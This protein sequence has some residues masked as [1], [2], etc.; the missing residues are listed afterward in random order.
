MIF[1]SGGVSDSSVL[2]ELS[3]IE[4]GEFEPVDNDGWN[5][6]T[7]Q[8]SNTY[9]AED[10]SKVV[11]NGVLVDQTSLTVTADGTYDTTLNNSI[12]VNTAPS[13]T[14]TITQNGTYNI[15][16]YSSAIVS[17]FDGGARV[18]SAI[19]DTPYIDGMEL[20]GEQL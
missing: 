5:K 11:D 1:N 3:V 12:T 7:V 19:L 20:K 2:G 13:G 14:I 18:S 16:N 10:E 6:V 17:V 8:V 15:R 9:S 4:N